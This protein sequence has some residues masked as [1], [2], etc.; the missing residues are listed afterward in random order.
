MQLTK[1][2][3]ASVHDMCFLRAVLIKLKQKGRDDIASLLDGCKCTISHV[4]HFSRRRWNAYW[5]T[6]NFYVPIDEYQKVMSGITAEIEEVIESVCDEAMPSESG[7]DV[8]EVKF[9]LALED[10]PRKKDLMTS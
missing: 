10:I 4:G 6:V 9:S 8:M 1:A 2:E 7:L 3:V 5:T